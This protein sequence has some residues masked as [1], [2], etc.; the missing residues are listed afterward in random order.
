[1]TFWAGAG[2]AIIGG[3]LS[4][5]GASS[6][7]SAARDMAQ[8]QINFQE[9]MSNTAH[10]REVT[11]LR[12]AGLNPILSARGGASTPP[13]AQAAFQNELGAGVSSALEAKRNAAEVENIKQDTGKKEQE[14][15]LAKLLGSLASVDYNKRLQ[16]V[17]T[18]RW[19]TAAEAAYA[20]ILKSTAVGARVEAEIDESKFGEVM[21]HINRVVPGLGVGSSAIRNLF[22]QR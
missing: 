2:G 19:R 1:M 10:Q 17:E 22:R 8:K 11:D 16:E 21:R 13:G 3:G 12:A 9:H 7:N 6:A 14:M 5:L 4:M 20:D 15:W 18:E